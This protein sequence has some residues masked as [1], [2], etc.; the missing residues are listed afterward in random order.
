[1]TE[2]VPVAVRLAVPTDMALVYDSWLNSYRYRAK[3]N[4]GRPCPKCRHVVRKDVSGALITAGVR[5]GD[6]YRGQRRRIDGILA[7]G[8]Y[9]VVVHPEEAPNVICA[10]ACLQDKDALHY[11]Y[12]VEVY[13]HRGYAKLLVAD[14]TV[15]THTTDSR[16]PDSFEAWR[17]R[18]GM[19]FD[20]Y[21]LEDR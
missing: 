19:R 12:T 20:P 17:R 16:R 4:E 1:M 11:V 13:R 15:C 18:M 21:L 10:W 3:D 6:Y 5:A 9:V 2:D 7:R 14:R 8:A